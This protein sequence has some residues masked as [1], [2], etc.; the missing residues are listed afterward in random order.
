MFSGYPR[1]AVESVVHVVVPRR[2][3]GIEEGEGGCGPPNYPQPCP[4]AAAEY[5][6]SLL[7]KLGSVS[8]FHLQVK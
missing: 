1:D 7:A 2:K 3:G 5:S 8:K 6:I 4:W